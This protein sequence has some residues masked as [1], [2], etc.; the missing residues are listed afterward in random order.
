MS[1]GEF[2]CE[3]DFRGEEGEGEP[4]REKPEERKERKRDRVR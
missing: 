1:F 4:E 3:L 2:F